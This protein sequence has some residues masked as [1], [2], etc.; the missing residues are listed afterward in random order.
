M[1]PPSTVMSELAELPL[2]LPALDGLAIANSAR[3]ASR[4]LDRIELEGEE[5]LVGVVVF[6]LMA[7]KV[8]LFSLSGVQSSLDDLG[9]GRAETE[10]LLPALRLS[11]SVSS[12]LLPG[13]ASRL[14]SASRDVRPVALEREEVVCG[15]LEPD[16]PDFPSGLTNVEALA[17]ARRTM[18]GDPVTWRPALLPRVALNMGGDCGEEPLTGAGPTIES[19][20]AL[21]SGGIET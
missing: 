5:R 12:C 9:E 2:L 3:P 17:P 6:V 13:E 1:N 14:R 15:G 8:R 21:I 10:D 18:E 4:V 11:D 20:I 7:F 16:R 19:R